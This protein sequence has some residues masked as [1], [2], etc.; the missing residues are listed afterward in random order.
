MATAPNSIVLGNNANVGIGVSNP[1]F[2]LQLSLD[3]A[4]KPTSNTWTIASDARL[5]KDI[6]PFSDGLAILRQINPVSYRLNGKAGM[7]VDASG[8]GVI[9]QQ[10]RDI[11]PYTISTFQAKLDPHD[12]APTELL[13][14]NSSALTFVTINAVKELS[15]QFEAKEKEITSLRREVTDL[16]ARLEALETLTKAQGQ[17]DGRR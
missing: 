14:F 16:K 7:K 15:A 3:S 1:G 12:P 11:I 6:R 8:I 13:S 17:Y 2:Q 4:A 5:K 10:V 9:A